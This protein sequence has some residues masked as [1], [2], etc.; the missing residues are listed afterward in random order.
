MKKLRFY[1]LST[2]LFCGVAIA[3][4]QVQWQRI[5]LPVELHTGHERV[6]FVNKNVRVGYPASLDGRLRLQSSGGTLYLKASEDFPDTRLELHDVDSGEII[7][8]DVHARTGG[9]LEPLELNYNTRVWRSDIS[10]TQNE[11]SGT[12]AVIPQE[13]SEPLP[14][15][16]TRYAAQMLYA[17]LRTV[18]PLPGITPVPLHLPPMLTTLLP[19]IPVTATPLN[20]WRL[21]DLTVTAIKLQN[22]TEQ[23]VTLDPRTLQGQFL[24]ATFQHSWLGAHGTPEDTTVVYLVSEGST[25]SAFIP[26]PEA[27]T[28]TKKK[29]GK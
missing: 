22:R 6:I 28:T 20:A 4:E 1:L 16:L 17:P 29:V 27:V 26:E 21:G 14:V 2:V 15:A 25:D 19:A 12:S 3:T 8:L 18:A 5:P 7:L 23:P 13:Y 9:E 10:E 24:T 11:S